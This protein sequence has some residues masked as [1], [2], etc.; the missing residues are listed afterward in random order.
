[1]KVVMA[2]D[3]APGAGLGHLSRSSALAGVLRDRGADVRAIALGATEPVERDGIAWEP[4]DLSAPGDADV[5]VLDSYRTPSDDAEALAKKAH[6]VAFHDQ[7]EPI[8]GATLVISTVFDEARP[9]ILG[10]LAF[11]PIDPAFRARARPRP[12]EARWVLVTTGGTDPSG[13]GA[14]VAADLA[15][16]FERVSLVRGPQASGDVPGDV[17][18]IRGGSLVEP[19]T[20]CDLVVTAAGVTLLEACAAGTPAVALVVADNQRPGAERLAR[21]GAIAL[22]DPPDAR[23]AADAARA[24][25]ADPLRR[26]ELSVRARN[27]VDGRGL[28]RIAERIEALS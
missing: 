14:T 23:A 8:A 1:V 24:L 27:L 11:A 25:A 9:G 18:P 20:R 2:A 15:G 26:R 3:A 21:E 7:G 4:G 17:E 28:E 6:L 13:I 16:D 12:Q 5:V 19:L 10:G 22:V